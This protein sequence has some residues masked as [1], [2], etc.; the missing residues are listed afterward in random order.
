MIIKLYI[1]PFSNFYKKIMVIIIPFLFSSCFDSKQKTSFITEQSIPTTKI[2]MSRQKLD[3]Y[4]KS[5]P[6]ADEIRI[7]F[8]DNLGSISFDSIA[9]KEYLS[10]FYLYDDTIK[11]KI[12]SSIYGTGVAFIYCDDVLVNWYIIRYIQSNFFYDF[13]LLIEKL[14]K[15]DSVHKVIDVLGEPPMVEREDNKMIFCY[16]FNEKISVNYPKSVDA[17]NLN[18]K[19]LPSWIV[20]S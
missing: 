9:Q 13:D 14:K 5:N 2:Y 10:L 1:K 11:N 7:K 20:L 8:G 17:P 19:Q 6:K 15:G 3:N 16:S 4:A 12:N 18:E